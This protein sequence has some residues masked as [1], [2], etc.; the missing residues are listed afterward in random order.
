MKNQILE[1]SKEELEIVYR[2]LHGYIQ[3]LDERI[4]FN[5]ACKLSHCW[6]DK[7][8][9]DAVYLYKNIE[10]T[11]QSLEKEEDL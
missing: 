4:K 3:T 7:E 10:N 1:F 8:R 2:A 9:E 5:E 11:L 6:A